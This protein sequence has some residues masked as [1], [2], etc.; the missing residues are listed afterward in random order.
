MFNKVQAFSFKNADDFSTA[1]LIT[2]LTADE[3]CIAAAFLAGADYFIL[4]LPNSANLNQGQRQLLAISR[5]SAA[6]Q[7]V[8]IL[9]EA[10]SSIDMRTEQLIEKGMDTLIKGRTV[11]VIAHRLSTV[12]ASNAIIVLEN[13]E[14]IKRDN[15]DELIAQQGKYYQLYTGPLNWN[16]FYK[17]VSYAI[18]NIRASTIPLL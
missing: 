13:G 14:I 17:R 16:K 4:Y 12:R 10:T 9:D 3:Q 5:V 8:L 15:I 11:F 6:D 2:R 7:S 1:S 18:S